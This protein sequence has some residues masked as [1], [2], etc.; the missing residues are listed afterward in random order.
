MSAYG[1][2]GPE[3]LGVTWT[4]FGVTTILI[5]LRIYVRLRV[6]KEKGEWSLAWALFAWVRIVT[7]YA[8]REYAARVRAQEQSTDSEI[9]AGRVW[10]W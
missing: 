6:V 1:G 2:R 5:S 10:V 4:L 7:C 9:S 8:T 3:I